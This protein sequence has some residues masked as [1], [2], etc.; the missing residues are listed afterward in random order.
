MEKLKRNIAEAKSALTEKPMLATAAERFLIL[1]GIKSEDRELPQPLRFSKHLSVLLSRV[2]TPVEEYDLIAGRYVDRLLTE[3]EE[4]EFAA[5]V[6]HSDYPGKIVFLSS[7][8]CS[9]SWADLVNEGLSGFK[10][11]ALRALEEANEEGERIF[12][13][14]AVE[15]L[16]AVSDYMLR[17]AETAEETGLYEV[18]ANLRSVAENAP[19][20]FAEALQLL[21]IVT[22][23]DCAYITENPTLTVGRLDKILYPLYRKDIEAGRLTREGAAELITDYYCKHNLIM[24]R[25]EHQVGDESN[26]TTFKRILNFDAP[27]YLLLGGTDEKGESAVNELTE[28]FAECIEPSF[29]NPVVVVRYFEGMDKAHPKLWRTLTD[30]ALESSSMMFYNDTNMLKTYKRIGIPD[31]D[32]RDYEHFGCNWPS[33][34]PDSAWLQGGPKA[35]KYGTV[36]EDEKA[37]LCAPFMRMNSDHGWPE[38][39]VTVLRGLAEKEDT[40]PLTVDRI[41]DG[42]IA[43]MSDFFSRKIARGSREVAARKRSPSALLSFRDCFSP[44]SLTSGKCISANAKYYYELGSFQMFATVADCI[45]V[46]DKLVITDKRLTLSELLLAV[47]RNFVGC[48]DVLALCRRVEKYGSGGALS[49]YHAKRLSEAATTAIIDAGRPYL[50][51]EGLFL[52]PCMQSDTWHLKIGELYGATPDGRRAGM[53]FSQNTRPSNGA[54]VN[55]ITGLFSSMLNLPTDGLLAG[56]LNLDVDPSDYKGE[57]GHAL[58]SALLGDYFNRGGLHAQVSATG[59]DTLIEAQ[60]DPDTHRDIRVRVT[61]YSGVFVDMCERLQNDVIERFK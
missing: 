56:A 24:G 10:K 8:H 32:A 29:K 41:Y 36:R 16:G 26:S 38:D 60:K 22:L 27:Q 19:K 49:N 1:N 59:V 21:W 51:R 4:R 31:A 33:L 48:E 54:A 43:R 25:G 57:D 58:F 34:G 14:G 55:G 52:V 46:V 40:E 7:G 15:A 6:K 30:K 18:A 28:I 11:K 20:T 50:E 2:S 5:F 44:R 61:G 37:E 42:F 12:L 35:Y 9:F 17:Y 45:T 13:R 23:I 39:L 3:E 53:P 47:D